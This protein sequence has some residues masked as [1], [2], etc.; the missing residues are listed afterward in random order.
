MIMVTRYA[1][2]LIGSLV[3]TLWGIAHLFPTKSVVAGFGAISLDHKRIITMEWIAEGL[4]LCFIGVLVLLVTLFAGPQNLVS[5]LVYRVCAWMLVVMAGL[6]FL[7]GAKTSITPIKICP[8]VKSIAA[9][10]FF[11]GSAW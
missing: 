11:V 4:T 6:T 1:L 8:L 3:I 7:T 9:I 10:L 2:T 5:I